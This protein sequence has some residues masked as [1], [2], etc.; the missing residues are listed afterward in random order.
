MKNNI[1]IFEILIL[2]IVFTLMAIYFNIH[3]EHHILQFV[4]NHVIALLLALLLSKII[5]SFLL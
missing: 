5:Y 2:T 3:G 1:T 4:T